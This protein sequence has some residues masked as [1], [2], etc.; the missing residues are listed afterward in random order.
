M[1]KSIKIWLAVA[2]ILLIALGIVCLCRPVATLLTTAWIIGCGTLIAG[3]ARMIFTFKTQAFLPNSGT[4]MLSAIVLI[5]LG[6]IL[7]ANRF[8]VTSSL[9]FIFAIWVIIEGITVGVL[10]FDYKKAGFSFWWAL[11][12]LGIAGVVLGILGLRNPVVSAQTLSTMISI[13]II[14]MGVAYITALC[15][16]NRFEKQIEQVEKAVKNAE[17]Q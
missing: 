9:P 15:G 1:S 2:G 13:G 10:S 3:I 7:L 8:F 6:I 17:I 4:R 11:L 14:A 5:I 12:L 16:I